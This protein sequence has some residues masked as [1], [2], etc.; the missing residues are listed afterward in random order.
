MKAGLLTR[1]GYKVGIGG[2][3]A[4]LLNCLPNAA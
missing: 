3:K 2:P 1:T 4:S